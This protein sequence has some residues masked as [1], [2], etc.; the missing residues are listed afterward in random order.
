[1]RLIGNILWL[2]FGGLITAI[3]WA[4][5]GAMLCITIIGIPL[6]LQCFKAAKLSL[7]PFGKEVDVNPSPHIIS[8]IIWCALLGW[9]MALAY[10][11]AGI[12][13][14]ITIIGIPNGIV[15]FKMMKLAFLPL[16]AKI[17]TK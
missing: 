15:A 16:G 14:C 11:L 5:S 7:A 2:L 6:G 10:L 1:M 17:R 12:F 4:L 13:C 3:L 9:E 8:N